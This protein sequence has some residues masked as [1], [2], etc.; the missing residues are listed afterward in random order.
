MGL[1]TDPMAVV[2][3]RLQVYDIE[4]LRVVDAS[5]MPVIVGTFHLKIKLTIA[6]HTCAPTIVIAEKAAE[7][8]LEDLTKST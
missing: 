7:M 8:I 1:K 5:V 4:N 3:P 6:A 2:S